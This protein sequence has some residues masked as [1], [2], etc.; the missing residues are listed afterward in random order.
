M[1]HSDFI[2][3]TA[4]VS[5]DCV[6]GPGTKVGKCSDKRAQSNRE[7]LYFVRTC[8]STGTYLLV[9]PAKYKTVYRYTMASGL[10]IMYS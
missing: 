8:M 6:I 2:H 10:R 3:P 5:D 1:R 4:I 7:R 9:T